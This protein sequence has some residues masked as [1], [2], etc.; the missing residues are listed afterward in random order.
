MKESSVQTKAAMLDV[1]G[2]SLYYE[3]R[4]SGSVLLM[5]SGAIMDS[6]LLTGLAEAL[7]DR[8][9]VV[10][11]DHRGNS[12]STLEGLA[13]DQRIEERADDACRLIE[14]VGGESAFV[15][16]TSSGALIGLDLAVRHP[17]RIRAVVAYEPPATSLLPDAARWSALNEDVRDTVG[18]EGLEP[19]M[20]KWAAGTGMDQAESGPQGQPSPEMVEAMGRMGANMAFFFA[21]ELCPFGLY[22]PDVAALRAVAPRIVIGVGEASGESQLPRRAAIELG[23]RLETNMA[24]FPGDH[25]GPVSRAGEFAARL[26]EVLRGARGPR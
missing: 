13:G 19:A 1:P 4:G 5:I 11:Y 10:T 8:Y 25:G 24:M 3:V 26:D 15:F 22:E 7:S 17:E 9:T 12:R 14:A 16:G 18:R 2:A 23:R 20:R 6:V 21:H